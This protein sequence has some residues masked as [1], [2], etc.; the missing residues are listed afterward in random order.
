MKCNLHSNQVGSSVK[1]IIKK[2]RKG[3]GV[4]FL[5]C[6]ALGIAFVGYLI[7]LHHQPLVLSFPTGTYSV[8]RTVYDWVDESRVDSLAGQANAK[9]ELLIWVWYPALVSGPPAP[10]LPRDWVQARNEDQGIGQFIESDFS[11][12]QTHSFENT[13]LAASP[14]PYPVIIMQ[15]GMGPVPTDY[16]VF[17]ENL[18]SH[19]Y[20][21]V[22]INPTYTSNLIVFPDG[23]VVP[24]S[25]KGTIPDDTDAA[26]ADADAN[27]IGQV[28]AEDAIFVMDQ[29]ERLDTDQTSLFYQKL[30]LAHIGLFGHSFGGAT[31]AGVC[32]RDVRCKAGADLDGT[33]FSYQAEEIL[34]KPFMFMVEDACGK[35]CETMHQA[36]ATSTS[37]AYYLTVKGTRHF[38]FSDL[39]L[40]LLPPVRILFRI[41]GYIGSIRP[42]RGLE[43]TNAYLV[44]FFDRYLKDTDSELLQGPSAAYPEVQL[45]LPSATVTPVPAATGAPKLTA[46]PTPAV[47]SIAVNPT[48]TY[49]TMDGIGA[50]SYAFP[51]ANDIGWDW[52][53]A[54][55]KYPSPEALR[56]AGRVVLEQF[57]HFGLKDVLLHAPNLHAPTNNIPWIEA[58]FAD[59]E[60]RARTVAV[61]Y[62]TWWSV[63]RKNYEAIWE[64]AQKYDKPVWATETGYQDTSIGIAPQT[65]RSSWEYGKSFYRAIAWSHASRVYLWTILGN[66]AAVGKDGERYPMFYVFKHF[67]NYISAG[68]VLVE[69]QSDDALVLS[70]VFVRPD[71]TYVVIL[72]NDNRMDKVVRLAG[73][74]ATI[75]EAVT[76]TEGA[77]EHTPTMEADGALLLPPLSVT[78]LILQP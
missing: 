3:I 37:A 55:I 73:L 63:D 54:G 58:W 30:D 69:S 42:E 38:N 52:E 74:P 40:R 75:V 77:Y 51:Y 41:A 21:V 12:I 31:A 7:V 44:A 19:G 4:T 47:V 50:N 11:S 78:S 60:L 28:W 6:V 76:T 62:H 34:Q 71:G 70:L 56:D 66:D 1:K 33:L 29:L 36:Y 5:L 35:N 61:S 68:S 48:I 20:I 18:A 9:R 59:D 65:W 27:R 53:E 67:A 43:I 39:P 49:Q 26:A 14:G 22:G 8:G 25:D 64:A 15:P 23:R 2:I 32:A 46:T 45:D 13:P 24:R 10:F 16:T 17:A 57:D 72:L